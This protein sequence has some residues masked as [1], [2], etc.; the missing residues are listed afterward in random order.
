M[1]ETDTWHPVSDWLATAAGS[2]TDDAWMA[3][4]RSDTPRAKPMQ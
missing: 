3:N 4:Q 1:E 2:Q